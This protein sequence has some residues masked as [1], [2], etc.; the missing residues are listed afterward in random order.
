VA[1]TPRLALP[2][3]SAIITLQAALNV[4]TVFGLLSLGGLCLLLHF[5]KKGFE[6]FLV[7]LLV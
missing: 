6:C 4:L 2:S 7:L 3:S 1:A 5:F